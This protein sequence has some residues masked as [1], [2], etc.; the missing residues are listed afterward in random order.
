[1]HLP[2]LEVAAQ[3]GTWQTPI[4][5]VK[6]L[7]LDFGDILIILEDAH[8]NVLVLVYTIFPGVSNGGYDG[9]LWAIKIDFQKSWNMAEK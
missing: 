3:I 9:L 1:L 4:Y 6:S 5:G 7:H 2:R 8:S